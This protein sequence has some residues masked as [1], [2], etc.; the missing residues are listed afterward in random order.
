VGIAAAI[1]GVA[2]RGSDAAFAFQQEHPAVLEPAQVANAVA[3][4]PEPVPGRRTASVSATC[5]PGRSGGALRNPWACTVRYRSGSRFRYAVTID[6][7]GRFRGQ[8]RT[9]Q[10]IVYGCCLR[11]EGG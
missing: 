9:G 10:R 7:S 1:V 8:D 11:V 5:V 6:A 4:G 3:K 2:Q